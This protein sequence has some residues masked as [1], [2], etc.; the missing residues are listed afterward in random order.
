MVYKI[1]KN[2]WLTVSDVAHHLKL[3]EEMVYKLLHS[4]ELPAIRIRTSWRI[5]REALDQWISVQRMHARY[6]RL[7]RPQAVVLRS[8]K[9]RLQKLYGPRFS[10]LYLFGSAAR[11]TATKDSDLDALVVLTAFDDRRAEL[12][13]VR[14]IAYDVSFG[15]GKAVVISTLVVSQQ[16]LLSQNSPILMRIREEG[17]IAA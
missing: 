13:K 16:E 11:G 3:S 14:D 7:P 6:V 12:K 1:E 5:A 2:P 17:R 15:H 10:E 4:G 8:L 9:Q